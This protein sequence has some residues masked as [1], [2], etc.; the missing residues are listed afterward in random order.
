MVR[1]TALVGLFFILDQAS[2]LWASKALAFESRDLCLLSLTLVH[3][4][5]AA[6][7]LGQN[8]GSLILFLSGIF[9]AIGFLILWLR[10]VTTKWGRW[11]LI[12]LLAGA[13]GNLCDRARLGAVIDFLDFRFFPVFNL[14]DTWI[15]FG[16]IFLA[17]GIWKLETQGGK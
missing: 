4:R 5:G 13:G 1:S 17:I 12:L 6:F 16:T 2:K 10:P 14:A 9:L 15:T 11:G 7:G 3:N 8:L